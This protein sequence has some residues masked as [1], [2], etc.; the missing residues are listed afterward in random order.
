MSQIA[1][2]YKH[3]IDK[4][5]YESCNM[6]AILHHHTHGVCALAAPAAADVRTAARPHACTCVLSPSPL[7]VQRLLLLPLT[8]VPPPGRVMGRLVTP[9]HTSLVPIVG[10]G[11]RPPTFVAVMYNRKNENTSEKEAKEK[12][13]IPLCCATADTIIKDNLYATSCYTIFF[14]VIIM[15][16]LIVST[17]GQSA[18][19]T[20]F[21]DDFFC[22]HF[23]FRLLKPK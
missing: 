20:V 14:C 12:K 10:R 6:L 2:L 5:N 8:C 19:L 23:R 21:K 9:L 1:V 13:N 17:A 16:E 18:L 7:V 4:I 15:P 3:H 22:F 11:R